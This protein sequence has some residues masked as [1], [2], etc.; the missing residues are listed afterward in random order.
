MTKEERK[1]YLRKYYKKNREKMD[2]RNIE[3]KKSNP[4]KVR[5]Y[6]LKYRKENRE[7]IAERKRIWRKENPEKV[8]QHIQ[9]DK[10]KNT[11][12]RHDAVNHKRKWHRDDKS[13]VIDKISKDDF[14]A[15]MT[16]RTIFA[17]RSERW[18]IK[19]NQKLGK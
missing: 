5:E 8:K 7:K 9:T 13:I 10:N 14:I 2:L 16:G 11:K 12:T 15:R 18:R 17:V 1:E 6:G 19:N 4:E 3:W